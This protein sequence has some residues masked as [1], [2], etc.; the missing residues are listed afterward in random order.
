M[1]LEIPIYAIRLFYIHPV[2]KERNVRF[3]M[4]AHKKIP[5]INN[6]KDSEFRG[7]NTLKYRLYNIVSNCNSVKYKTN[8]NQPFPILVKTGL[9]CKRMVVRLCLHVTKVILVWRQPIC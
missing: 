9:I 7:N 6:F 1:I 8:Q 2:V 4:T 5:E 3:L